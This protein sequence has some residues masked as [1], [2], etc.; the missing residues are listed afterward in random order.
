MGNKIQALRNE[1][2]QSDAEKEKMQERLNILEKMVNYHLDSS[3]NTM[4]NGDKNDQ[5]IDTGTVVEFSKQVNISMTGKPS[6]DLEEAIK[7]FFGDSIKE[8]FEK[9][10]T[11][12]VD[13]VLGNSSMGEHEGSSMFIVWSD[14]A[15]LRLDAYYYRWNFSSHEIIQDVE[16]ASGTIVMK[17]VIDLTHT[18]PQV[19]TWAISKQASLMGNPDGAS[20]MI[21]DAVTIIQKV[22]TLQQTVHSIESEEQSQGIGGSQPS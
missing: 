9:V 12:A 4:L 16:G 11:V 6:D 7:S 21:D 14:N 20:A 15:L 1:I 18:D 13:S 8:G 19:L 5:E 10:V 17:R 22:A 2:D 3:K